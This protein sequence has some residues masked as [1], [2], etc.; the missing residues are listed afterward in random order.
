MFPPTPPMEK[1]SMTRA[2]GTPPIDIPES[3]D[4]L[5]RQCRVETFRAGGKGGQHQNVTDSGVRL[6]HLLSGV[7]VTAR[8]ERSQYRNKRTALRRLRRRL[9]KKLM[10]RPARV[11][12]R[13]PAAQKRMRREQKRR[14]ARVKRLRRKP[15][16]DD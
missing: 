6:K 15:A 2:E 1:R 11:A 5:L 3:D 8:E 12:T 7:V 16:S 10:R 4:D 14:R 13:V 9:E